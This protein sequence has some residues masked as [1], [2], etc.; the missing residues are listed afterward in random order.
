MIDQE[1]KALSALRFDSVSSSD[2]VWSPSPFHVEG[3]HHDAERLVLAGIA[4]TT[5][6]NG[7]SPLGIVIQGQKGAGKTHLLGWVR[8]QVQHAG[9]YFFLVGLLHGIDFWNSVALAVLDGLQRQVSDGQRQ[10]SALL[11]R[12]AILAG[13]PKRQAR[14]IAGNRRLSPDDLDTF[15]AA[16][17][18]LDRQVGLRCQD[19]ARALAL[20]ASTDLKTSDVGRD[21]LESCKEFESADRSRW[22]IRPR[23][24]PQQLI[25]QEV[26]WLLALTGP[27]VI[28]VDQ[29]DTLI[30]QS[31]KMTSDPNITRD[32]GA[33]PLFAQVADGLMALREVTRGTLTIVACLP[34]SW[35]QISTKAGTD[36]VPDRFRDV[37]TLDQ[38]HDPKLAK[39]LVE[40]RL[41]PTYRQIGFTPK[42]PTWPVSPLA[43]NR[44][45]DHTPRWLLKRIDKHVA[46]CLS[47][48]EIRELKRLDADIET[49]AVEGP[50]SPGPSIDFSTF[51]VRFDELKRQADVR[52][53][54]DQDT[55]D[56]SMPALLSAGLT[57]WI[58]ERG[59]DGHVWRQGP[60]PSAK[61]ALHA[62]LIRTLDEETD[63]EAHWAFRAIGHRH[64]S[65]ALK[66]LR[67]ARMA[68]GLFQGVPARELIVLRNAGWS[69]GPVTQDELASFRQAGGRDLPITDGD[70]RTFSALRKVLA[71]NEIGLEEWLVSRQPASNT[72]LFG[73]VLPHD[74]PEWPTADQ[75]TDRPTASPDMGA[76]KSADKPT[77]MLG[78]SMNDGTPITV[79]L[80][81]LRNHMV[82]FAGSGSGKTVFIRRVVE[83]CALLGVSAIVLD[84]NNDLARLGDPWPAPPPE[85][86]P[87]DAEK[88]AEYQTNTEVM[89]WTPGR[90]TARP[91]AFRA[92]PDFA[93]VRDDVDEFNAAVDVAVDT[94]APRANVNGRSN[95]AVQSKA[96]LRQTIEHYGRSGQRSLA[97]LIAMLFELPDEVNTVRNA[98]RLAADM[99][100]TLNAARVN[101]PLFGDDGEPVDPAVL[102]TPAEGKR[103]RISVISFVGLVSDEQRQGFVSQLQM[104]L[105]AW[106]KR[107]PAADRPLGGLFVIDEAQ[108]IA[109]AGA[110]TASTQSTIVLASQARKYGLGLVFATQVPKGLHNQIAGNATTM[111]IGRLGVPA[112]LDAA[113]EMARAKGSTLTG[114]GKL[115]QG[116]FYVTG[117]AF[118]FR[119][120]Q[121]PL[122]LSHH[123]ASP[124]T[125][126]EVIKR[127]RR[128]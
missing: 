65:A 103:A 111:A 27:T 35:E 110:S 2:D 28:A 57:A 102:L 13:L 101:D 25:V 18:R 62:Q 92:L 51:D 99:A 117:E 43:F 71:N 88:A 74:D 21:Y 15:A 68:A 100:D 128:R 45:L 127:A 39:A 40:K 113:E 97:G 33:N 116:Q 4:D 12:L 96:V 38:I 30:A 53:A 49:P 125:P 126:E 81:S 105:F 44:P 112:Q 59:G 63:D 16:L 46:A 54:L 61:P 123:P 32:N 87:G 66:R 107:Y 85:W 94:L 20:Y 36:T 106:I 82:I 91:L 72:E 31:D 50:Q 22:G 93:S 115:S 124:L 23:V 42:Y 70:L 73:E 77:V 108:T 26:S 58:V 17:L 86:Q 79:E 19:T 78:K 24:K 14:A 64:H 119:K 48:G 1:Y 8:Q 47:G 55:E 114:V 7:A 75:D 90:S 98:A 104:E 95:K 6:S 37:K 29:I 56:E 3:L 76:G 89:I 5:V 41:D 67:N 52:P 60:S 9:G 120:V 80:K 118:P 121:T 69:T 109:P 11:H 122:C 34:H 84:P 10:L 83:E